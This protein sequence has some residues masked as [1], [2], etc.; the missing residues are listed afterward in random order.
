MTY[1]AFVVDKQGGRFSAGLRT[2]AESDLPPG[3]VTVRVEWSTVN[4]KDGLAA[5]AD[6]RVVA[7]YP[8]VTGVDLAGTV[9][10]SVD[11]RFSAGDGVIVTG[12]DLGTAHPGG[13]AELAR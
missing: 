12:F 9:V 7:S 6:G 2:L 11:T 3:E 10:D 8:M 1:R 4:F 5:T 13:F